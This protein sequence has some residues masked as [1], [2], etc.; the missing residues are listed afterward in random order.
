MRILIRTISISTE[1]KVLGISNPN[2]R[3]IVLTTSPNQYP[4]YD[5]EEEVSAT[6]ECKDCVVVF[7][8]VLER[9]QYSES[10][11]PFFYPR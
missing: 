11:F 7:D 3:I 2:R 4:T 6:H 9:N 1:Q 5:T 8:D 10:Y